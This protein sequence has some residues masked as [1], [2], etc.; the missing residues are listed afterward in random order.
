MREKPKE[1][2]KQEKLKYL[3]KIYANLWLLFSQYI[4]KPEEDK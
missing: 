1:L 2:K 3:V 4:E